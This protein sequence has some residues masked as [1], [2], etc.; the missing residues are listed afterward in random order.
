LHAV[1][2]PSIPSVIGTSVLRRFQRG[3]KRYRFAI[4]L[5]LSLGAFLPA[6]S[7]RRQDSMPGFFFPLEWISP[8]LCRRKIPSTLLFLWLNIRQDANDYFAIAKCKRIELEVGSL[9]TQYAVYYDAA[10]C[11]ELCDT[12]PVLLS[13]GQHA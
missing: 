3:H 8:C 6:F 11:Y 4:L 1:H 2:A 12:S 5:E 10:H 13:I 7:L 9:L